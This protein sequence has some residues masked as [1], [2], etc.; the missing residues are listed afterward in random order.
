MKVDLKKMYFLNAD[1]VEF[2][3][4][5]NLA[6]KTLLHEK[7]LMTPEEFKKHRTLAE[8]ILSAKVEK[9]MEEWASRNPEMVQMYNEMMT[10]PRSAVADVS[11]SS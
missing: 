11:P 9:Q 2:L 4:T 7:G 6:L 10:N 5:E 8:Q 3:L 1:M